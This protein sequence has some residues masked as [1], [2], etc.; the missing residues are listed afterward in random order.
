M[1]SMINEAAVVSRMNEQA[2]MAADRYFSKYRTHMELL[3]SHS[4]LS[5][6]RQITPYDF[7]ALGKQLENFEAYKEMCEDDGTLSQLGKIPNVAFDVITVAYGTA[8]ISALASV[9]PI[10]EERGT[11]YFKN[12]IAQT[13]RGNVTAGDNIAKSDAAP[14][15]F[16]EGYAS[17]QLTETI[18]VLVAATTGYAGGVSAAGLPI[19]P[20]TTKVRAVVAGVERLVE[21][22]RGDGTLVGA[23]GDFGTVDYATG[24]VTFDLGV[25]QT[26]G[27]GDAGNAVSVTYQTD[28]A[29]QTEIPKIVMRLTTKSVNARV[30]ALKDTIGLEQSYALRRR[31]GLI[32]ED[33]VAT[34]LVSAIN[35][36]ITRTLIKL[37][38]ANSTG[39]TTLFPK[40]APAGVSFFEHKQTSIKSMT[41]KD[42]I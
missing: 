1:E 4:L 21:D 11:V 10:D 3:E 9:Q 12:V 24:G 33:E 25:A 31:F 28:F 29:Q 7:Y 22:T 20:F 36:E 34:D 15:A 30:W 16:P 26:P 13:T 42:L 6:L 32:A 41:Y 39:P 18:A 35:S 37:L 5:K 38:E 40:T 19:R 23:G 8:P 2:E 14:D 17:D 27:A